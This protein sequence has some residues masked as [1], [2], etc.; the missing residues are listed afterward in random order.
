MPGTA[1]DRDDCGIALRRV[2][3]LWL[4]QL[5]EKRV[6]VLGPQ[7]AKFLERI[8]RGIGGVRVLRIERVLQYIGAHAAVG[9]VHTDLVR[10]RAAGEMI[11]V[12]GVVVGHR[13]AMDARLA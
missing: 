11:D 10:L 3:I 6:S 8:S 9:I 2:E 4:E 13:D 5:I 1:V 7:R 12:K